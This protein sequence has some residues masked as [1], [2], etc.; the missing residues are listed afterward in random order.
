MK[1][2]K[3]DSVKR[4]IVW[5]ETSKSLVFINSEIR[6]TQQIVK[7]HSTWYFGAHQSR[8]RSASSVMPGDKYHAL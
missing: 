1:K 7:M 6:T 5:D 8:I 4:E 3:W 2:L